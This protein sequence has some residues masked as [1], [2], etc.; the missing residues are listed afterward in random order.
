MWK[1]FHMTG[2]LKACSIGCL[3]EDEMKKH[4]LMVLIHDKGN[5]SKPHRF[6]NNSYLSTPE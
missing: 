3:T 5:F 1:E 2:R 6:V 4:V